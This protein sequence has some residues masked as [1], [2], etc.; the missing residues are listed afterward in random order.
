MKKAFLFDMDGVIVNSENK[1]QQ[2]GADFVTN[3]YGKDIVEKMGDTTGMSLD[4]EYAFAVRHGFSMGKEEFYRRYDK[5]AEKV[6]A[7]TVITEGLE[8][9]IQ[10]LKSLEFTVG[11][12][13]SSRRPWID[14]VLS[15]L[16]HASLF[17]Y[18]ISL[19][20]EGLPSKPSPEGYVVAMKKLGATPQTTIILED[21]N[22][23]IRAGKAAGA[24]VIG[25]TPLLVEGYQ[26]IEADVKANSFKEVEKIVR[27]SVFKK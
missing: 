11:I 23:G 10:T 25:F 22:S 19:N 3:L 2:Y 12:V 7:T 18:T 15:K 1:W 27:A 9:F 21:S 24:F 16:T 6:Y 13:S 20:E 17:D 8:N 14:I 26:Q 5:Q 4:H